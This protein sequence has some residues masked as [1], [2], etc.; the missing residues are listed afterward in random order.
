[1]PRIIN[2]VEMNNISCVAFLE[3][4]K[5]TDPNL[6][7]IDLDDVYEWLGFPLKMNAVRRLKRA[8]YN[9]GEDYIVEPNGNKKRFLLSVNCMKE[10]CM[11]G[12]SD[13][14]QEYRMYLINNE[15]AMFEHLIHHQ[16]NGT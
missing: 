13:V 8:G 16:V 2:K 9:E 10:F 11:L 1:M 5:D 15:R 12:M 6:F 7:T 14:G 3:Q 4:Y